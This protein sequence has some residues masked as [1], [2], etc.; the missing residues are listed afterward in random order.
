[1]AKYLSLVF[2]SHCLFAC[3]PAP[4]FFLSFLTLLPSLPFLPTLSLSL[5][6]TKK[7]IFESA[8]LSYVVAQPD[9]AA[10]QRFLRARKGNAQ[11]AAKMYVE[12]EL[13]RHSMGNERI[14]EPDP[15]EHIYRA[16]CPHANHK[17]DKKGRPIYM[18]KTGLIRLPKLLKL[19]TPEQLIVR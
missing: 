17:F 15:N 14:F 18:E 7:K 1:M 10:A 5:V 13:F 16:M 4:S 11:E 8:H 2:F 9:G 3:W 19:V 6:S 12:A